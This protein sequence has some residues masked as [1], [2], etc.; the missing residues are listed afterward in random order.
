MKTIQTRNGASHPARLKLDLIRTDAGTQSRARIDEATV[1]DYTGTM[2]RCDQF[3]PVVVFRENGDFVLADGFHRVRAARK[4]R[5]SAIAA[6]IR[7]GGRLDALKYSLRANHAHGLRRAN[8]DKRHAVTLALREFAHLSDGSISV[9]VGVSQPFASIL[10]R[11]L[12][13]VLSSEKRVGLDGKA[14]RMPVRSSPPLVA[15]QIPCVVNQDFR[16]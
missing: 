4:A 9:L 7:R 1:A 15:R 2:I 12:K 6:E 5:F 10:R 16:N 11:E 8:E 13:S 3:P 14:R